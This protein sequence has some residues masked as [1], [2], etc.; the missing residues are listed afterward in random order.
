M[1][2][3]EGQRERFLERIDEPDKNWMFGSA[4]LEERKFWGSYVTAYEECHGTTGTDTPWHIVP[5]DDK[6]NA[7][8]VVSQIVL[9]TIEPLQTV[10]AERAPQPGSNAL[11]RATTLSTVKPNSRSS[12]SAGAEAPKRS[13]PSMAPASPT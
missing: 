6:D 12:T 7:R 13:M 11:A 8:L 1:R 4:D 3:K 2:S 5:A 10:R 9:D